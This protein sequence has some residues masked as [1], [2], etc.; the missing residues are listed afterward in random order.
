M[1]SSHIMLCYSEDE[2]PG[3][4][5][6]GFNPMYIMNKNINICQLL[7]LVAQFCLASCCRC[8][9]MNPGEC[10]SYFSTFAMAGVNSA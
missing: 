3:V 1:G 6:F 9:E 7:L 5:P 8:H 2:V 4:K 10:D